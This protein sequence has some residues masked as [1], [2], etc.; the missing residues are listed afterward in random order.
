MFFLIYLYFNKYPLNPYLLSPINT[1][2]FGLYIINFPIKI[3]SF[4]Y[5]S[6]KELS[7]KNNYPIPIFIPFKILP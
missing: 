2:P 5:P 4:Q 6:I 1:E 3:S 7:F